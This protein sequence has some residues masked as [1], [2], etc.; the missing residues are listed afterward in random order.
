MNI[1]IADDHGLFRE[2]MRA[3]LG[4]IDSSYNIHCVDSFH[5]AERQLEL[6]ENT[7]LLLVDLNMPGMYGSASIRRLAGKKQ[8][9]PILVVSAYESPVVMQACIRAG[10]A[11]YLPK[12]SNTP[13][14]VNAIRQVLNGGS[15]IPRHALDSQ[16]VKLSAR[17]QQILSQLAKGDSNK[18]IADTLGLSEGTVKQYVSILLQTLGVDNRTR[19]VIKAREILGL[20]DA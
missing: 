14:M 19:A 3:L 16:P 7:R 1:L 18:Q 17:Q 10:A 12:S 11:G 5:E 4:Q 9:M 20:G 13:I 8:G 15:F 2:G 6:L